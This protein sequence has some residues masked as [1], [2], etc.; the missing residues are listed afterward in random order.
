VSNWKPIVSAPRDLA[1]RTW[2]DGKPYLPKARK[3]NGHC[4]VDV[5]TGQRAKCNPT[6]WDYLS[7]PL[8]LVAHTLEL[9]ADV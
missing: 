5:N 4:F 3:W 9:D 1:I 7:S 2:T 6:H 8:S